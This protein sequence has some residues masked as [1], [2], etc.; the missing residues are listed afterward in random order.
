MNAVQ[1]AQHGDSSILANVSVPKPTPKS[2]Q[3]LVKVAYSGVNFIDTYQRSGLYPQNLPFILG[4]EGS[5]EIV[6]VGSEAKG[7]F[8]V[9][10]RV[11]FVGPGSYA[12][13][14]AVSTTTLAKL[15]PAVS[16]EQVE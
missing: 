13:Y 8:Q 7:D 1:I 5:G 6:E 3:V 10:D 2:D 14:D 9:G 11:A 16:L 15:P 4:R 12:E